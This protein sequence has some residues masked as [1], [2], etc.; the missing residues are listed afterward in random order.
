MPVSLG[1][2]LQSVRT[3]R[4]IDGAHV[5]DGYEFIAAGQAAGWRSVAAWGEQGWDLGDWPYVVVLFR[6][7]RGTFQRAIYIEGDIT[8]ATYASSVDRE[9]A[10]DE[11]AFFYWRAAGDAW[12]IDHTPGQEPAQLRGPYHRSRA[13]TSRDPEQGPTAEQRP[14]PDLETPP[15]PN[16]QTQ[17]G[18]VSPSA[19]AA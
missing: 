5:D 4:V 12:I 8:I 15:A 6:E 1:A 13:A 7:L 19:G 17:D 14:A 10:T 11:T 9:K 16:P 18:G 3:S 2:P